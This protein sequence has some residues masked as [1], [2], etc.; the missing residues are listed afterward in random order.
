ML[1]LLVFLLLLLLELLPLELS[2]LLLVLPRY[3]S[4]FVLALR[5]IDSFY[6]GGDWLGWLT[7]AFLLF[8]LGRS[9]FWLR[10]IHLVDFFKNRLVRV[11]HA[12][13]TIAINL[14][15]P[16]LAHVNFILRVLLSFI[17]LH[18]NL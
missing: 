9:L 15:E 2:L 6:K 1:V 4:L 10:V 8:F 12:L 18:L 14:P 16:D 3:L 7:A 13:F 5:F 17:T 11:N